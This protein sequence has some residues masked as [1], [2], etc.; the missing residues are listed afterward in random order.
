MKKRHN[1]KIGET[2]R[3]KNLQEVQEFADTHQYKESEFKC[4]SVSPFIYK[5]IA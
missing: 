5:K 1:L 3:F 2:L 4:T